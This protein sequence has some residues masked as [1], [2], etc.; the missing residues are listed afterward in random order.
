MALGALQG[1]QEGRTR[2]S[3]LRVHLN[4]V[5]RQRIMLGRSRS[6]VCSSSE[7]DITTVSMQGAE[8]GQRR[9]TQTPLR[10]LQMPFVACPLSHGDAE[11]IDMVILDES[12]RSL[13]GLGRIT[14][15]Q[16]SEG[17]SDVQSIQRLGKQAVGGIQPCTSQ[18]LTRHAFPASA[19]E[20]RGLLL[21]SSMP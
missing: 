8:E 20:P 16:F 15:T 5:Q 18:V 17:V 14:A 21:C 7:T 12:P 11:R 4:Q 6:G 2:P 3:T 13:G 1:C 10:P 9:G 19:E